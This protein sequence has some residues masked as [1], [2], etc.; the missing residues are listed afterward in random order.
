MR[1]A[2]LLLP[3]FLACAAAEVP[4]DAAAIMTQVAANVEA[5]TEARSRYVYQ[6]K[7]RSTLSRSN[8]QI[9]RREERLYSVL[10]TPKGS[11]KKLSSFHGEYRKGKEM[12]AYSEPGFTY[13]GMDIDGELIDDLTGDLVNDGDSRDGIPHSLFPLRSK[14]LGAYL[15]TW[16]GESELGGRRTYRIAFEP[17]RKETCIQ[18]GS[19][20]EGDCK[21]PWRGEALIDAAELQPVRIDTHLAFK[22]PWA[23]RTFLGTNLTQTGFSITYRRLDENV[24]FPS[25]YGTE[26]NLKAAFFYKRTVILSLESSDFRKADAQSTI[27]FQEIAQ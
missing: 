2:T 4:P 25:T 27:Q 7:V 22:I 23:V 26:F 19:D 15:F 16:K 10:P 8:G 24:W 18:I 14:D 12:I 3:L 5:G 17:A 20:S 11:E 9:A 1:V 21:S 13:K 6:Q